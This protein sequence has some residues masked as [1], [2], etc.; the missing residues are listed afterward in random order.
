M[1]RVFN[2][3]T[4]AHNPWL[5]L[6]AGAL[7]FLASLTATQL[8][9][10]AKATSGRAHALW[11]VTAAAATGCGIWATHFVAMLA[12]E[13]GVPVGYDLGLTLLSLATAIVFTGIGVVVAFHAPVRGRVLIGGC[14][15][16]AG[17][18]AMHYLGMTA[19]QLPGTIVWAP[20]LLTAATVL[21]VVLSSAALALVV[22]RNDHYG[23]FGAA[24]V[25][26]LGIVALHFTAMGAVTILPDPTK[27]FDGM[28][29]SEIALAIAIANAAVAVLGMSLGV[30]FADHRAHEQSRRLSVAV[31][32]MSQGLVMFDATERLVICNDRYLKMYGLSADIV[33]PGCTLREVIR[34]RIATGSLDQDAEAYRDR[35]MSSMS[36]HDSISWIVDTPNGRSISVINTPTPSGDWVATHED[37]TER[38]LAERELERTRG[39][40]DMVIESV[41]VT[42]TVKQLPDL[43]YALIN[44]AGEKYFGLPRDEMLGKT[45]LQVFPEQ[46]ALKIMAN[47][48]S[49]VQSGTETFFDIHPVTTPGGGTRIVTSKLLPV[50]GADNQPQYLVSVIEDVTERKR[51]EARLAHMAHH[52]LLT[53]LPNRVAFNEALD[54]TL[55]RA[56]EQGESFSV[57]CIDLDHF[58]EVNDVFGHSTGD[59][60]LCE[61]SR[62]LQEAAGGAF[63]ARVGGDEFILLAADGVQPDGVQVLADRLV[64]CIAQEI[65]IDDHPLRVGLSI[66]VAVYP[67]DGADAEALL[68]NADAALY[69]VKAEA[70]GTIRF[71]EPEMD[72]RLRDRRAIQ[73]DLATAIARSELSLHYQ[74]QLRIGGEVSGFEA[75]VRW[76]HPVR[77][78]V[79]PAVF[80]PIAEDSGQIMALGEWVLREACRE[81]ATWPT[82]LRIAVNLSPIQFKHGD[83]AGLVHAVLLETGLPAERL[84]L[85]ITEGVL[86]GDFSR[87]LSILRRLKTL[88]VRIAMDDFGTG[89]SSLSYLQAFPFDKI[90]IDQAFIANLER[91]PQSAAIIRAVIGLGHGLDLPIVAE[92]VET[93]AQFD[94]LS[95]ECC[96][97]VQGY[98]VGRPGPIAGFAAM[99]GRMP[100]IQAAKA[101]G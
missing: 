16:G 90:K 71:F 67:H 47:D 68:A 88:G 70:R 23:T 27:Q 85:E 81:A 52:D 66:G 83:L 99:V 10:R 14:L 73:N 87:A 54:G 95:R 35:L 26:T 40:L 5:V 43:R 2:C 38:R 72:E 20:D 74:P 6:L 86:I 41:P 37:I 92:G 22:R 51:A 28:A 64:A 7:C 50:M 29:L 93:Q 97:E 98:L 9:R 65:T 15:V 79:T 69:R 53:D 24:C 63:I 56:R 100:V 61:V 94:F 57:M 77:G 84:E 49:V 76:H 33:K 60:L 39:F 17:V 12:Y 30:A 89:Y 62:R 80:I 59:A 4:D 34:H 3:L 13:P 58:K 46:T 25:L 91:N 42:I 1:F 75:L 21:G 45:A 55:A 36:K 8:I 101:V 48:R 78:N 32:N 82:P 31:S 18:M 19:L 44:R 11:I 96:D